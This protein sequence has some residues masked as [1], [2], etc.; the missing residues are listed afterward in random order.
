MASHASIA[1]N[2]M[3]AKFSPVKIWTTVLSVQVMLL[4]C[5][6]DCC[7]VGFKKPKD[8]VTLV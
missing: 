5:L 7:T 4:F 8:E 6:L 1:L 3:I 2:L